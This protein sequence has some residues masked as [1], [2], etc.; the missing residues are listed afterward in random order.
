MARSHTSNLSP[1][2]LGAS[3]TFTFQS[4]ELPFPTAGRGISEFLI[5]LTDSDGLTTRSTGVLNNL[6]RVRV[7]AGGATIVDVSGFQLGEFLT[8]LAPSDPGIAS[9]AFIGG[10][11]GLKNAV[12]FRVPFT[13]FDDVAEDMQDLSQFPLNKLPTI[14][15]VTNGTMTSSTF[16]SVT[17]TLTDVT[18]KWSPK[19]LGQAMNVP[20]S[21]NSFRVP[22]SEAGL[23]RALGLGTQSLDIAGSVISMATGFKRYRIVLSN[24]EKFNGSPL[25]LFETT[26]SFNGYTGDAPAATTSTFPALTYWKNVG[27]LPG[28]AGFSYIEVD[29]GAYTGTFTNAVY[30]TP[31]AATEWVTWAFDN[32]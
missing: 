29:S 31:S 21:A 12:T 10:A 24:V 1:K 27:M 6:S 20:A 15:L 4:S 30:G 11:F 16:A 19:L 8:Q 9:P 23:I 28:P 14:E 2:Q 32:Q 26:R 25:S 5:T 13:V 7:R 17:T 22:I 18:P 3:S